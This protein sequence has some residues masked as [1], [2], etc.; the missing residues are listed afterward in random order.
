MGVVWYVS[1]LLKIFIEIVSRFYPCTCSFGYSWCLK[2]C[3]SWYSNTSIICCRE[4]CL[5][6]SLILFNFSCDICE[7]FSSITKSAQ[8]EH[9]LVGQNVLVCWLWWS[10]YIL[11]LKK[12]AFFLFCN[13]F[14]ESYFALHV[15]FSNF[16]L[17]FSLWLIILFSLFL[18]INWTTFNVKYEG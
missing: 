3:M 17:I 10:T 6:I 18:G 13:C 15:W 14:L 5:L 4:V 16:W 9:K 12:E 11:V 7:L 1:K 2:L 8:V